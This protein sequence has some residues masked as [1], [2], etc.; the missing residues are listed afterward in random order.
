M[1]LESFEGSSE[2]QT[3]EISE[4]IYSDAG[5]GGIGLVYGDLI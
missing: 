2:R 3:S 4:R 5:I 1:T